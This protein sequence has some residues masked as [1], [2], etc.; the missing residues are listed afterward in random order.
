MD[1]GPQRKDLRHLPGD[2][3]ISPGAL[4]YTQKRPTSR[5]IAGV[6]VLLRASTIGF[7][8]DMMMLGP[9]FVAYTLAAWSTRRN[10]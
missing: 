1:G 3:E 2:V 8:D 6:I 4:R 9:S 7:A 5:A 10:Y